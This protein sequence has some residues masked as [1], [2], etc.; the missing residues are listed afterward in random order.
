M[1]APHAALEV[2]MLERAGPTQKGAKN[3]ICLFPATWHTQYRGKSVQVLAHCAG[4]YVRSEH[5]RTAP[6]MLH[7]QHPSPHVRQPTHAQAH[8]AG[9]TRSLC[10]SVVPQ[11]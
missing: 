7:R 5:P 9:T 6:S 11:E 4:C 1:H 3:K 8:V 2:L 10:I